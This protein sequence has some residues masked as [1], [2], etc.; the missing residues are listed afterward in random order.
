MSDIH[1]SLRICTRRHKLRSYSDD[2]TYDCSSTKH[3]LFVPSFTPIDF[4]ILSLGPVMCSLDLYKTR[5]NMVIIFEIYVPPGAFQ[6][7]GS[8]SKPVSVAIH[9]PSTI[10]HVPN[11][12]LLS[13]SV[14]TSI[15]IARTFSLGSPNPT[16]I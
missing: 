12:P 8:F 9:H 2:A 6:L 16:A 15:H 1:Q 10:P 3:I 5:H 11:P 13:R 14:L 4:S 7:V